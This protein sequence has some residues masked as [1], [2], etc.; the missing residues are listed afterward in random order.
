M[1]DSK[2]G[3]EGECGPVPV[4]EGLTIKEGNS[5]RC[6]QCCGRNYINCFQD[7]EVRAASCV[8]DKGGCVAQCLRGQALETDGPAPQCTSQTHRV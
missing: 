8:S 4:L 7:T 6:I 1:T 5:S 3:N 2:L